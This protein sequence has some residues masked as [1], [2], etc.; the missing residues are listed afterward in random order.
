MRLLGL[1][2][3]S[4]R[5]GVAIGD[6][7][8]RLASPWGVVKAQPEET[9]FLSLRDLIKREGIEGL[10]I[11]IPKLL[12]ERSQETEQ[13]H[14]IQAWTKRFH[15]TS[16]QLVITFEDETL[17]SALATRWQH[18]QSGK[19]KR[20]DLAALAILQSYLDAYGNVSS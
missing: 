16:P 13:Q 5:I 10:V 8:T 15:D 4:A 19:G 6:T 11:G 14:K 2:I 3:G 17:S 1:D 12:R 20:D 7:E 9:A 18:E